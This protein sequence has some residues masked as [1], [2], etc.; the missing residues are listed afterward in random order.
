[1]VLDAAKGSMGE[2]QSI[3]QKINKGQGT[4][5][6]LV[7]DKKI[8]NEMSAATAQAKLGAA[9]FQE[10]MEALKHNFFLR[11]F[12]NRRGYEDSAKLAENEIAELP[13]GQI[14]KKFSYDPQKLFGKSDTA[15]I[16]EPQL[17]NDAGRFL[18]QN[19]FGTAVVTA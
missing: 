14:L 13:Q 4:M 8:Y 3:G 11:G 17:L 7:N 10:N 19:S 15:K 6:A 5:G 2:L 16:K 18:E 9:A 1:E 12:F